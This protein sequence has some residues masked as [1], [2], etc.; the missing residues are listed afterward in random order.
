MYYQSSIFKV[1]ISLFPQLELGSGWSG[2]GCGWFL[3]FSSLLFSYILQLLLLT[4]LGWA[5]G[6]EALGTRA[7][8]C[9][10]HS[11]GICC[12]C[13]LHGLQFS[14]H[15]KS[16]SFA[17]IFMSW[18]PKLWWFTPSIWSLL[19]STR[20]TWVRVLLHRSLSSLSLGACLR[21]PE[22]TCLCWPWRGCSVLGSLSTPAIVFTFRFSWWESYSSHT[23]L[24]LRGDI[25]HP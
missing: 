5:Q 24:N 16:L 12:Q 1:S 20:S 2:K 4:A 23:F 15:G 21:S 3:L 9:A 19:P 22:N 13:P 7:L 18:P 6:E 11:A 25:F 17:C 8:L 10:A 14:S